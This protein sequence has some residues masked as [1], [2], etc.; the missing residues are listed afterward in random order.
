[1]PVLEPTAREPRRLDGYLLA[2]DSEDADY[3]EKESEVAKRAGIG[4]VQSLDRLPLTFQTGPALRF[5]RQ[6]QFHVLKY[7]AG[8]ISALDRLE[9]KI[10]SNTAVDHVEDGAPVRVITQSGHTIECS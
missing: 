9:T 6:G 1:M 4:E 8:V 10:Y 2:P 3:I 7:L 5:S